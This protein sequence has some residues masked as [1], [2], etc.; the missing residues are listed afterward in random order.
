MERLLIRLLMKMKFK[1][2]ESRKDFLLNKSKSISSKW[3]EAWEN[4]EKTL[5]FKKKNKMKVNS[6]SIDKNNKNMK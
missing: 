1:D 2:K 3:K 6:N 4:K 5:Y